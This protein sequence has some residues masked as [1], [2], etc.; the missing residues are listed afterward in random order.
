MCWVQIDQRQRRCFLSFWGAGAQLTA[1]IHRR[2]RPFVKARYESHVASGV[3]FKGSCRKCRDAAA[4]RP[5]LMLLRQRGEQP[6]DQRADRRGA[7][8]DDV[9]VPLVPTH[10]RE[11]EDR[12][13]LGIA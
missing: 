6:R 2:R 3:G 11:I 8:G 13:D 1:A 4:R 7:D 9:A 5:K 10:P 12:I